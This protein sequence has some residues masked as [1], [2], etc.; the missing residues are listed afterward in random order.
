MFSNYCKINK[1]IP[2]FIFYEHVKISN[3]RVR[4][5]TPFGGSK[6]MGVCITIYAYNAIILKYNVNS[7]CIYSQLT[8]ST[9]KS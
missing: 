5:W 9:F 2:F 4:W 3:M 1:K 8:S 7:K 6:A